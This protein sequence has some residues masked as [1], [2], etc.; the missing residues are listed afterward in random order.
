MEGSL[1]PHALAALACGFGWLLWSLLL[2]YLALRLPPALLER[3][4]WFTRPRPWG[5]T[6]AHYE[7]RLRIRRWKGYL[8]DAGN[9]FAGGLRKDSLVGRDPARL[10]RLIAETRRAELVHLAIW[11]FWPLT[12]LWLPAW[13]VL[14]NL[15]FATAFNLPC[16]WLQRFNRLRLLQTINKIRRESAVPGRS[17]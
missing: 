16:L 14:I 1:H 6:L 3:D 9:A 7:Q 12:A 15:A 10:R 4:N 2:G 5:E 13:A 8:P 11:L 17:T